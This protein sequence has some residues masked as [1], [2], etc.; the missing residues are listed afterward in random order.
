MTNKD[1]TETYSIHCLL[2]NLVI[3]D[4]EIPEVGYDDAYEDLEHRIK[5]GGFFVA[6][7]YGGSI[8]INGDYI[9]IL[10][11]GKVIGLIY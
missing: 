4:I 6:D 2:D 9:D 5:H 8:K 10:N 3:V 11:C 7:N 1:K